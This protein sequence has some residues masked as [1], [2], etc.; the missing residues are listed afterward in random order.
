MDLWNL[1]IHRRH[2]QSQTTIHCYE[3]SCGCPCLEKE[4]FSFPLSNPP[5]HVS[6]SYH[7]QQMRRWFPRPRQHILLDGL[8]IL[9]H[10]PRHIASYVRYFFVIFLISFLTLPLSH[11]GSSTS[12]CDP[13]R[14][15]SIRI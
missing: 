13:C 2:Q 12:T 1:S 8:Q 4:R 5:V 15:I 3:A 10:H 9:P 11:F 6:N 7:S 14:R